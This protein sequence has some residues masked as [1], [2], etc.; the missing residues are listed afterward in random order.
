[1]GRSAVEIEVL[2]LDVFAVVAFIPGEAEEAL[3]ENGIA[4]V[5]V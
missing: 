4:A 2:F 1:M 5:P 3:F